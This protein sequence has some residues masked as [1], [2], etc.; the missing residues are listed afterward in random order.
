[1]RMMAKIS[2]VSAPF[3]ASSLKTASGLSPQIQEERGR[4]VAAEY[5]ADF[6]R[7]SV[8]PRPT[9][10]FQDAFPA[11]TDLAPIFD[12]VSEMSPM[13]SMG[14]PEEVAVAEAFLVSD[15]APYITGAELLIG[16]AMMAMHPDISCQ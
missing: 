11:G 3:A 7:R 12:S 6:Q 2:V 10:I 8:R 1:M 14:R 4:Q 9:P 15:E 13:R 16:G 5:G